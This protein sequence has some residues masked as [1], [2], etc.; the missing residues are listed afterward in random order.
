MGYLEHHLNEIKAFLER[1]EKRFNVAF[2]EAPEGTLQRSVVNKSISYIHAVPD[3]VTPGRYL[4]KV[5]RHD[6]E[7]I[8]ALAKKEY[9]RLALRSIERN[10][11]IVNQLS[12]R[13]D[14]IEPA[15]I[16]GTMKSAYRTL[17]NSC[18]GVGDYDNRDWSIQ[19][20][21]AV[22]DY[23]MI[24]HRP[25]DRNKSSSRGLLL[26]SKSEV[27]LAEKLYEHG[28]PFRYEESIRIGAYELGPDFTFLD[29]NGERFYLE[30]CGMMDD[31]DYIRK[32]LWKR[33]MYER[34]GI[35]E[36]TNMIYIFEKNNEIHLDHI[37][38]II[39][40]YIIP[41]M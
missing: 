19:R 4:R 17:P 21:W 35:S 12:E 22:Q 28:V 41:R 38:E 9:A 20:E 8:R 29:S 10:K 30:Y 2:A 31:E 36:W 7:L 39:R 1:E 37:D 32:F 16:V 5:I 33:Q 3:P 34:V 18:F 13:M 6:P 15:H 14:D 25:E 26:R 24:D 23:E 27:L 40:N 11:S